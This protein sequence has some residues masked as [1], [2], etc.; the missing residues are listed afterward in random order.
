MK[1]FKII[2]VSFILLYFVCN[3][4]S[5]EN[6]LFPDSSD[7]IKKTLFST[8]SANYTGDFVSNFGGGIKTGTVYLGMA[9]FEIG[10]LTKQLGLWQQGEFFLK[11]VT[12]HGAKPSESL[13]GDFQ[14]MSNIEAGNHS[15]LQELW[16]KHS[17]ENFELTI[18]LQDLNAD[19]LVSET[20]SSFINSSF[21]VPSLVSD[22]IPV[23]IFPLTTLG[24]SAKFII[25]D[26]IILKTALFDGLP[27]DFETN[28]YNLGWSINKND[29]LIFFNELS[30][31]HHM[32][33]LPGNFKTG[34][35]YHTHAL[36]NPG[37]SHS[38]Y[39]IYLIKDQVVSKTGDNSTSVFAQLAVSP[40]NKN[41][42]NYYIGGGIRISGLISSNPD[43][44]LGAAFAHAGFN[45]NT[46][47]DETTF[48]IF[49]N[50]QIMENFSVKPDVQYIMN[51]NGTG[52]N[53][54]NVLAGSIRFEISI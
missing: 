40:Q 30:I 49:Y 53:L 51:P 27:E 52:T 41:L 34:I 5:Q 3:L 25:A 28:Q 46:L 21:G 33:E 19:F 14:I 32:F 9:S 36:E 50:M 20:G 42:H 35:Y 24:I 44:F 6:K 17:F 10:S 1:N 4:F 18:G 48:E 22:N 39:G 8:L 26:N 16:Y 38:N 45:D 15:Y 2:T 11:A 47:K 37:E 23:S 7:D 31:D 12:T 54:K 13:T 43:C 29:G